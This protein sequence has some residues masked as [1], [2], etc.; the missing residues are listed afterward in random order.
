M[1]ARDIAITVRFTEEEIKHLER[2]AK[3]DDRKPA[4]LAYKFVREALEEHGCKFSNDDHD[5]TLTS[6]GNR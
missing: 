4:Y 6:F 5:S 1:A 3:S 2:M